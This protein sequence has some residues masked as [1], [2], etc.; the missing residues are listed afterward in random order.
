[1]EEGRGTDVEGCFCTAG[2]SARNSPT[3][4]SSSGAEL[5]YREHSESS[6]S[7]G[8]GQGGRNALNLKLP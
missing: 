2:Y 6:G 3:P 1:M 8:V 4:P 5:N 7:S